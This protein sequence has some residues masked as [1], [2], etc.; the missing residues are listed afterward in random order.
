MKNNQSNKNAHAKNEIK[1]YLDG[2]LAAYVG[3]AVLYPPRFSKAN[4][5]KITMHPF[6][7]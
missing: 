7:N 4:G 3:N 2:K 5:S 6:M 1:I